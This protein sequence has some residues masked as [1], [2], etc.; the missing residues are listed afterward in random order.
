MNFRGCGT[1]IGTPFLS[2][3]SV[4]EK[5]LRSLVAWQVESKI[6]FLVPCG[7][8]GETPTLTRDEWL[9]VI[10][11]TIEVVAGRVPI[12]AGA[13]SNCTAKAVERA[14]TVAAIP[15]VDA[16]LTASPYYNKPTQEGQYQ[17]FKA[18]AEAVDKPLVLYNVPGR[19]AANIEPATLGRLAQIPNIIAVKE[20]SGNL[21]QIADVFNAVPENFL[22]FS[23]DDAV[24]LPVISLGGVGIIS[25]ASNE[26][27]KEMAE[28]TR[29]ALAGDWTTARKIHRQFLPLMQANFLESNPMPVKCVL[30]LMGRI[31]ENYRP[32]ML[33]VKPE[34]RAKLEKIAK[35][36]GLLQ[37][38][39]V[40]R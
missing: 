25:V 14:K 22:V 34:T 38:V 37:P 19:T 39:A 24:T 6:D 10:E 3:G 20:A 31:E 2:D 7:T 17:H 11:I 23:G 13:T 35:E 8:T 5:A 29:A 40:A 36:V 30:A 1:A 21:S 33:R 32:P 18:I 26:I 4:D 12:V 16:I 9:R 15:G 27:P 28:M